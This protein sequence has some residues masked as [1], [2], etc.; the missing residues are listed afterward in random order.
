MKPTKKVILV[1]HDEGLES[2]WRNA[3]GS[4]VAVRIPTLL[5]VP[6]EMTNAHGIVWVDLASLPSQAV[7]IPDPLSIVLKQSMAVV[8]ASSSPNDEEAMALLD[9][10][11]MGYCHAYSDLLTLRQVNEVVGSGN[12]WIGKNLMQRLLRRINGL[13]PSEAHPKSDWSDGLTQREKQVA[14]LAANGASNQS[15]AEQCHITER[16]VKAHLSTIF[17][18]MNLTDRLQ[19]ALRVHGIH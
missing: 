3:F 2:H 19:L 14:I 7:R 17:Q 10:G 18:K 8:A 15:I 6:S 9:R 4:Q 11:F 5:A 13:A 1:T 16:T 12:V